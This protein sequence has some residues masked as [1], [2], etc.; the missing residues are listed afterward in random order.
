[1]HAQED[2]A[3][4]VDFADPPAA[5]EQ[6]LQPL[7]KAMLSCGEQQVHTV[8]LGQVLAQVEASRLGTAAVSH[9]GA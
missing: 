6:H 3:W 1:M 9:L 5:W 7:V 2:L 4:A 8:E